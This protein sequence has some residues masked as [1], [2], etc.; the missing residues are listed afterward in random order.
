M[1]NWFGVCRK[2][3][4]RK[5]RRDRLARILRFTNGIFQWFPDVEVPQIEWFIKENPTKLDEILHEFNPK[6]VFHQNVLKLATPRLSVGGPL[7][8]VRKQKFIQLRVLVYVDPCQC[9]AVVA[10]GLT[11]KEASNDPN[12]WG[13]KGVNM[14]GANPYI[15]GSSKQNSHPPTS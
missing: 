11:R 5:F 15:P 7:P 4:Y 14:N 8:K 13:A 2:C 12:H 10:A 1:T 3:S 6:M 9:S